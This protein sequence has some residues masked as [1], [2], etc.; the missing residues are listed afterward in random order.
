MVKLKEDGMVRFVNFFTIFSLVLTGLLISPA[1][2]A[3]KGDLTGDSFVDID[4]MAVI[5]DNWLEDYPRADLAPISGNPNVSISDGDGIID[6]QDFGLLAQNWKDESL[7]VSS[8]ALDY[9]LQTILATE[10]DLVA[11]WGLENTPESTIN[12]YS[13]WRIYWRSD[14]DYIEGWTNG[15]FPG[16]LWYMY[17]LTGDPFIKIKA[18]MWTGRIEGM[19]NYTQ[20][21]DHGF[22]FLCSFRN[23]YR[24]GGPECAGFNDVVHTAASTLAD[25]GYSDVVGCLESWD[26]GGYA[27]KFTTIIDTMMN[28]EILFWSARTG[29]DPNLYDIAVNHA[30]KTRDYFVRED[31]SNCNI[32][33]FDESTGEP[34][35][36]EC[37]PCEPWSRGQAWGAH[38][39]TIA[40]RETGDPNFLETA[41]KMTDYFLDNLPTDMVPPNH[42]NTAE[43]KDSSA[44]AIA[45]SGLLELCTLVTDPNDQERYYNA[46]KDILTSLTTSYLDG[47]YM[48]GG[49]DVCLLRETN[50]TTEG[51]IYADYYFVEALMRYY[52][53][54]G[55]PE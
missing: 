38:G 31:G 39:F 51:R 22:V 41:Q 4:D 43:A 8:N 13:E 55:W 44:S 33:T 34:I 6:L 5:A 30:Y 1:V 2:G 16:C 15:F 24:L 3:D 52:D 50:G 29:G 47:G 37:D 46:A 23:G 9:C 7:T 27:T 26:W 25:A 53:L 45:A 12:S 28:I 19:K 10:A 21:R 35:E 14:P 17:E 40:Y 54:T 49:S 11:T 20:M 42:F 32:I 18:M 48:A 36:W